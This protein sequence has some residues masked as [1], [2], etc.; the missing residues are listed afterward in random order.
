MNLNDPVT[1]IPG[2]GEAYAK[3]LEKLQIHSIQDLLNHFPFRYEDYTHITDI[4]NLSPD[5]S[6]CIK[7][8]LVSFENVRT[9]SR[10]TL[11]KALVEDST[12]QAKLTWFNQ[13]F[14]ESGLKKVKHIIS[15]VKLLNSATILL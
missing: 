7:A 2:V 8:K 3:R 5:R 14:L 10:F 11:Q 12:G 13:K 15:P 9:K 4:S 1:K 6:A